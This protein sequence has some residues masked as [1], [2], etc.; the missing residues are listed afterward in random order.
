MIGVMFSD[1]VK[2][3]KIAIDR[4]LIEIKKNYYCSFTAKREIVSAFQL[5]F[6]FLAC[7]KQ[8]KNMSHDATKP[9][10]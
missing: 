8:A 10:K 1:F 7:W 3:L 4:V 2:Y 9:T 6:T 5:L